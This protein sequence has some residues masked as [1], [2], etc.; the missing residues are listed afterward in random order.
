MTQEM[1]HSWEFQLMML[2][3][4]LVNILAMAHAALGFTRTLYAR[5]PYRIDDDLL[6]PLFQGDYTVKL[7]SRRQRVRLV[8]KLV[9]LAVAALLSAVGVVYMTYV[10][11]VVGYA[12]MIGNEAIDRNWV[13]VL[14]ALLIGSLLGYAIVRGK[15]G[16]DRKPATI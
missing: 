11:T 13:Y 9:S 4:Y 1:V 14:H 3:L 2:G 16:A 10:Y 15:R 7:Y 8:V 12:W 6:V 5:N